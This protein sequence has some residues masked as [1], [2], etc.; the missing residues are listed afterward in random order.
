MTNQPTNKKEWVTIDD[1]SGDGGGGGQYTCT[2]TIYFL[3]IVNAKHVG[4]Y[5]RHINFFPNGLIACF[6]V[7]LTVCMCK[8]MGTICFYSMFICHTGQ[9]GTLHNDGVNLE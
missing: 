8:R 3:I 4:N 6:N 5:Y 7:R 2:I 1:R 9:H